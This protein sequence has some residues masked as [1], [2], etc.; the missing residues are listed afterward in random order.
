M[1]AIS[2]FNLKLN[3][4]GKSV[5]DKKVES[6]VNKMFL[7]KDRTNKLKA[8]WKSFYADFGNYPSF[9][10]N[11]ED[12]RLKLASQ[13]LAIDLKDDKEW[14]KVKKTLTLRPG[15]VLPNAV[16]IQVLVSDVL[17]ILG[18]D[19][20]KNTKGLVRKLIIELYQEIDNRFPTK[21]DLIK[22]A[23]EL[24]FPSSSLKRLELATFSITSLP[25]PSHVFNNKEQAMKIFNKMII[26]LK[27][28]ATAYVGKEETWCILNTPEVFA[29]FN[30][31]K[32]ENEQYY[33]FTISS[34]YG[35]IRIE[36]KGEFKIQESPNLMTEKIKGL[37]IKEIIGGK[38][39][40]FTSGVL[41]HDYGSK[42]INNL[43]KI[44]SEVKS[45][46][47]AKFEIV[48]PYVTPNGATYDYALVITPQSLIDAEA[49]LL[50][51]FKG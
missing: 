38:K 21:D 36:P 20:P 1:N 29:L 39:Q 10:K 35:A 43:E 6:V 8:E 16:E 7:E 24:E 48:K 14:E 30:E 28:N 9:L 40:V 49:E 11:P 31:L 27:G 25:Q 5:K 33:D 15:D 18:I 2:I 51:T 13:N 17:S 22:K 50:A 44:I 26:S 47:D 42:V 46:A 45:E 23:Q 41:R 32:K 3:E 12:F 19:A 4:Q 37:I 34:D